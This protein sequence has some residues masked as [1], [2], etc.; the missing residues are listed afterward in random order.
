MAAR[1]MVP[2]MKCELELYEYVLVQNSMYFSAQVRTQYMLFSQSTVP[3][4]DWYVLCIQKYC[5]GCCFVSYY[6]CG[7]QDYVCVTVTCTRWCRSNTE[8]VPLLVSNI[9]DISL[10]CTQYESVECT[11]MSWYPGPA[12][13]TSLHFLYQYRSVLGTTVRTRAGTYLFRTGTY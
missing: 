6:A 11:G 3:G 9:H 8:S 10:V 2:E 1:M 7:K 13:C 12:V 5:S 4:T